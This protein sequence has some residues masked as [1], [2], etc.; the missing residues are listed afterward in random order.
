MTTL[1]NNL[2]RTDRTINYYKGASFHF[3]GKWRPGIEYVHDNYKTDFVVYNNVLL[4]CAQSHQADVN[5]EPSEFIYDRNGTVI[6][7]RSRY[8]DFVLSGMR[9]ASPGIKIGENRHW[10]ICND[11]ENP[12][13]IDT[14]INA[15]ADVDLSDEVI[16]DIKTRVIQ[17]IV[18]TID[19][20]VINQL[21]DNIA[22][23]E[24]R[25]EA[26]EGQ[27]AEVSARIPTKVSDLEND[28]GYTSVTLN[29][30]QTRID[31]TR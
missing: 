9:G 19:I 2:F 14:G 29:E 26:L 21:R 6:G 25:I 5:N 27:I 11:V 22:V 4:A 7:I 3:S 23:L 10:Y 15:Q 17:E 20:E 18:D 12:D 16:D 13:W 30:N 24:N 31:V 8:W 28:A 1:S